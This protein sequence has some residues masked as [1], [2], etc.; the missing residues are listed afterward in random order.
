MLLDKNKG[1]KVLLIEDNLGDQVLISE[2][3]REEFRRLHLTTSDNFADAKKIVQEQKLSFNVILMDLSLPKIDPSSLLKEFISLAPQTPIIILAGQDDSR[4]AT[5]ALTLGF[6]DYLIKDEINS[7]R[8]RKSITYAFERKHI[9]K[10]LSLSVT[11]YQQLFQL[12]PQPTWVISSETGRFLEVNEAALD[13]YGFKRNEMLEMKIQDIDPKYDQNKLLHPVKSEDSIKSNKFHKH[14]LK[15]GRKIKVRVYGN[16][17]DYLGT[18]AIILMAI[19]ISKTKSYIDQIEAQN[20]KLKD[21]AWEQ[22]H[23]V[24]APLTRLMGIISRL[25]EK[26]IELIEDLDEECAMLLQHAL[27]SAHEIDDVI[28]RIVDKSDNTKI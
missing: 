3:L 19:D 18:E 21:I 4:I 12:N 25:E 11:R 20:Q 23:M 24:R 22:S 26:H 14:Q 1:L 17:I 10:Q 8:L 5:E 16:P 15:N 28:R 2:Y 27:S 9:D 6:T 13:K 7:K